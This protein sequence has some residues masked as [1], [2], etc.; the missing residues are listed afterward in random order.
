MGNVVEILVKSTD[1]TKSGFGSANKGASSF[2]DCAKCA[3]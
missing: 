2:E 1:L 3:T